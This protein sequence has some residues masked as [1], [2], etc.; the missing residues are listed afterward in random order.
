MRRLILPR[1]LLLATT[2]AVA[3]H[4]GVRAQDAGD[5]LDALDTSH[6]IHETRIDAHLAFL[7]DDLLEGRAPG[8]R[9]GR[10]AARYIATQLALAGVE[11][12]R[13]SYYQTV[14]LV[15]WRADTRRIS[16]QF[17]AGT[18]RLALSHPS[19]AVVWLDSGADSVAVTGELV[20]VG[21]GARA[22]EYEWD[23]FKGRDLRGSILVALVNDPPAQPGQPPI[24]E[25]SAMTYYGRWTYK[26]EEARRRG[27]A[28]VLIVHSV[29]GAGYPWS[30]VESS[31]A[32][33][34]LALPHDSMGTSPLPIQGWIG[35][36]AARRLLAIANL[37]LNELFVRAARRDFQ[38][39]FTGI[40]AQLR[41]AGRVRRF[42]SSNVVGIVRGAH[43]TRRDEAVVF[44]AHYDGL[45]IG[46][47]ID[48][49]SIYNGAYDNASGVALL[50]E[51]ARAF[52][53]LDSPPDRSLLFNFTTAE[54]AGL[55]G[56]SWY[57][58]RP[59]VPLQRTAAALNID[60]ANLWGETNDIGAVGLER[61]T[62]G[63]TFSRQAR[64]LDLRVTG[65]R[66]P[67]RGF[68]FRSDQFPFARAGVPALY[69]DHGTE[70]R[71]RPA[72]WGEAML[73][74]YESDHY[75]QPSDR[76]DPA[77]DLAGAVQQGRLAFLIAWEVASTPARP[78][79]Y[80]GGEVF[81]R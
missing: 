44:T 13:D 59:F 21:Y 5:A 48:G 34:R 80:P 42:T 56:A 6:G 70:F 31:F 78:R 16:L 22:P 65:E 73:F 39:V 67:S 37:D 23:D 18:R 30:V 33:E 47:P 28:G 66:A 58:R 38:P 8:T 72:G 61:S 43:P 76:Y 1:S 50:L 69:L 4:A 15:G 64:T 17:T 79:W 68:F 12:G 24:F 55:L 46:R 41:A 26:V 77:F 45:G 71:G 10:L 25:G 57:V 75:H 20:F 35:F 29:E 62:L 19:D 81:A 51:I 36:D 40:T 14:P 3:A 74:R 63:E 53:S 11:P 32:G 27:A 49:D 54:E 9:G 2:L 7:A 60:G 52:A